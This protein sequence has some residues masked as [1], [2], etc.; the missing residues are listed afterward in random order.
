MTEPREEGIHE[1]TVYLAFSILALPSARL[2]KHFDYFPHVVFASIPWF[3]DGEFVD[4]YN[5][6]AT[7]TSQGRQY[8]CWKG[9]CYENRY[10]LQVIGR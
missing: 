7:K 1:K 10:H 9:G 6:K 5:L 3:H 4:S 2:S 8:L